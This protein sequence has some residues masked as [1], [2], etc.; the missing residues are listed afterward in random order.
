MR[1]ATL[2][3]AGILL[4]AVSLLAGRPDQASQEAGRPTS[5]A[6]QSAVLGEERLFD[7]HIPPGDGPF[8]VIYVL[9]GQVQFANVVNALVSIDAPPAIV[10]GVG[11]I[12]LRDRDYT[13]TR[14]DASAF[15]DA[16][17]AAVSGGGGRFITH[18]QQELI[19]YIDANYPA[20]AT[21]TLVGHS[22]GGLI[23]LEILLK[24]PGLFD[25]FIVID[26]SLWWDEATL[27]G[28]SADLLKGEFGDVRL[29]VGIGAARN[30]DRPNAEAVREDTSD[31]SALI[32][33]TVQFVDALQAAP[34]AG[35]DLNWKF[36]PDL[37]HMSVFNPAVVDG[38][39]FVLH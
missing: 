36:Y 27:L 11:N 32:R 15:V 37:D 5:F 30:K 9:D 18:I 34:A 35:I 23:A 39:R 26:P 6:L 28:Q 29:F 10:V 14:V 8:Q 17:A 13:P 4:F 21:R 38:L 20:A 25:R 16:G 24:H 2:F 7:V 22:L 1:H 19:P 12:W 3:C 31:N 33:P